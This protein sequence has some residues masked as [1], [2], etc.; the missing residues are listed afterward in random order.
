LQTGSYTCPVY[1]GNIQGTN[2]LINQFK[3]QVHFV[4]VYTPEAHPKSPDPSPYKGTA[5]PKPY[6]IYGQSQSYQDRVTAAQNLDLPE[7]Q[8]VLIDTFDAPGSNPFW[9]TYAVE[10]NAGILIDQ[11]GK[12]VEI[13]DWIRLNDMKTAIEAL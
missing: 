4:T 5:W 7:G 12:I 10:P 11:Q 8:L 3:D 1:Q 13:H 6:S 2:L 9:C